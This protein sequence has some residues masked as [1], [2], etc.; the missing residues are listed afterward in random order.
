MSQRT[1]GFLSTCPEK[2]Q[3]VSPGLRYLE[4][5]GP[6]RRSCSSSLT[7]PTSPV[8]VQNR[9]TG[10]NSDLYSRLPLMEI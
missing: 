2:K 9:R 3:A 5:P 4:R 8:P 7:R 10:T 1:I 6:E